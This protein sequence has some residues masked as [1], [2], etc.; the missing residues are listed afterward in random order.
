MMSQA[1][2]DY[3]G[4]R[5][6]PERKDWVLFYLCALGQARS[7]GSLSST[8]TAI[9]TAC[10][11]QEQYE[12]EGSSK[13][14]LAV[15]PSPDEVVRACLDDLPVSFERAAR[16]TELSATNIAAMRASRHAKNLI[17]AASPHQRRLGL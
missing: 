11:V 7:R 1:L 5:D 15:L 12:R 8:E 17:T 9:R 2:I 4:E 10:F 16:P 6:D 13:H 14:V 3:R